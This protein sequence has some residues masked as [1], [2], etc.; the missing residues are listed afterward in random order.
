[1]NGGHPIADSELDA[2]SA[3]CGDFVLVLWLHFR[4]QGGGALVR[5]Q[6]TGDGAGREI[7]AWCRLTGHILIDEHPPWYWIRVKEG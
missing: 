5:V 3:S 7:A 2:G 4:K 1:M 6:A